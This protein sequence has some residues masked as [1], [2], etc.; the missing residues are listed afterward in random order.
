MMNPGTFQAPEDLKR[1]GT[2]ALGIGGAATFVWAIGTYMNVE[3][4]LRSWLLGFIFWG[5]IAIGSLGLLMLQYLTGGAWGVVSRRI[6]EAGSKTLLLVALLFLPIMIGV[7]SLYEFTHLPADDHVMV[8]RGWY[9]DWR[10]WIA[11]TVVYF[12]LLGIMT[13]LLNKWSEQQDRSEGVAAANGLLARASRFSGPTMVV[14]ALVVTFA[15]VD[16]VMILD[17][18]WFSTIF[19][20]LF[21]IGWALSCLSFTIALLAS[22]YDKA[23]LN[24][25]LGKRHFHDLGKLMLAMVMVWAYFNFSQF[26]IIWSGNIPEET[27]WYIRRMHGG[28]GVIGVALV[29]L[30][31]AFPFLVLLM[32]DFKRK[33]RM[34]AILALFIL[35][36]RIFDIYYL[37]GPS[38]RL[39]K[40][41]GI[42]PANFVSSFSW[43]DIVAPIA[44]GGIWLWY[45]FGQLTKR[46]LVPINDPYLE[47]AIHHGRGH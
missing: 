38:D 25:V 21:V 1:W 32:Q 4:G 46:P 16:W 27:T 14:Y 36:M 6:F 2:L 13:Y 18:H 11:R 22:L 10:W 39:N 8:H 20:L 31:F 34:L 5:G 19:G 30:H 33:A 47:N 24:R 26:L 42:D 7:R 17:P 12:V 44:V 29:I 41:M 23:P 40:E 28:W 15:V 35:T 9:M 43:L 45:F 37:I 3:Q